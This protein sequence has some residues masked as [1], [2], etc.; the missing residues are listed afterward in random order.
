MIVTVALLALYVFQSTHPLRGA[1]HRFAAAARPC[2]D[3]N[4]RT[5]CGVRPAAHDAAARQTAISIHAPLAGCDRHPRK[6]RKEK[7][8]SIHAPLAGCDVSIVGLRLLRR[9]FN[10]RTPCGVRPG[11]GNGRGMRYPISIHAPLAGCDIGGV[12]L[13]VQSSLFQSTHPLRGATYHPPYSVLFPINF[14]PRTPCG[15]RRIILHILYY[16]LLISIHAPLAGCDYKQLFAKHLFRISIHAPLAGCDVFEIDQDY[17]DTI[18]IH[19]PLAGC[20]SHTLPPY[21]RLLSYF[22]PRTPCGVRH[23]W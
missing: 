12:D 23:R 4:P 17:L 2:S 16:F 20:D 1:T 13:A 8:I 7:Y 15:V 9:Y 5:P 18:S 19:A 6:L 11:W 22:N 10:P 3:F 21:L 14:N